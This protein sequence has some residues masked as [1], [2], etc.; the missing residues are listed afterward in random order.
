MH[1]QALQCIAAEQT[2]DAEGSTAKTTT[3]T[4]T[5]TTAVVE[6]T[7]TGAEGETTTAAAAAFDEVDADAA[8]AADPATVRAHAKRAAKL[9][10]ALDR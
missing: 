4:T 10:V 1:T 9:L 6:T 3:T 2:L 5:A 7:T 8:D